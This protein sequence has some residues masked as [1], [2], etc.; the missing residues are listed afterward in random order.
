MLS[1]V[2]TPLMEHTYTWKRQYLEARC[3]TSITLAHWCFLSSYIQDHNQGC[4]QLF[5]KGGAKLVCMDYWRG[6]YISMCKKCSKLG[7]QG[8]APLG[9]FDFGPFTR[10]NL[11][12]SGTVF[13]QSKF[14]IYCVII[15]A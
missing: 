14:T 9:N 6:K 12:E 7:G 8:H 1:V 13:A 15:K 10:H 4:F 3:E 2:A 11:V 5:A